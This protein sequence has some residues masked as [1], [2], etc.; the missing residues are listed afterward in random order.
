[1]RGG[2]AHP[3]RVPWWATPSMQPISRIVQCAVWAAR[4]PMVRAT[5][6]LAKRPSQR[7]LGPTLPSVGRRPVRSAPRGLEVGGRSDQTPQCQGWPAR[8]A[9]TEDRYVA[10]RPRRV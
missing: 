5:I 3:R 10:D 7:R 4:S 8:E 9:N 2:L 6:A 1:M